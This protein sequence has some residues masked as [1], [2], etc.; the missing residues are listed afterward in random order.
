MA[1]APYWKG[2]LKLSLV[3]C[4]VQMLPAT[5][6]NEKV[7]FRTLNRQ[8]GNPVV[9][10]YVDSVTRK[11]VSSENEIK[12]YEIADGEYVML[13]DSELSNV[14][15]ESTRTIDIEMFVPRASIPWIWLETPYYLS[16][17]NPVGLDAFSVIRDAMSSED[18]VGISRLV[19]SRRERAV[20]IE[21]N[22]K[23]IVLWTLRY[24]DEI[25][26]KAEYFA[27]IEA[28]EVDSEAASVIDQFIKKETGHWSASMVTDP[29]QNQL[30]KMIELKKK[31][32]APP[33]I[34]TRPADKV[35]P[36]PKVVNIMEAL[37]NS[38]AAEAKK[39]SP[40]SK[41]RSGQTH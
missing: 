20:M 13:T 12:G 3:T 17:E 38:M 5:T 7:K 22:G 18:M 36:R 16:L 19:I 6:E 24:G 35:A 34:K 23:G 4:P 2:Y 30:L 41:P 10:Q 33:K 40:P 11:Q 39:P 1:P 31:L 28:D 21:P 8:T 32:Q 9:S 37:R 29:V 26:D 27:G 15:L 25:R 14:A